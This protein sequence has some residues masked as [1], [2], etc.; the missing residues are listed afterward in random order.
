MNL[1]S[2]LTPEFDSQSIHENSDNSFDKSM[3]S[4]GK[5]PPLCLPVLIPSEHSQVWNM[6]KMFK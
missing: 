6:I 1:N 2:G 4:P 3:F 5:H